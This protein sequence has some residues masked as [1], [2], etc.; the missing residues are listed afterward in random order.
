MVDE[1]HSQYYASVI[2]APLFKKIAEQSLRILNR[3][4]TEVVAGSTS[5]PSLKETTAPHE[6]I[7]AGP[8]RWLMPDLKGLSLSEAMRLLNRYVDSVQV[9][10]S[11]YVSDQ[12]PEP[13]ATLDGKSYVSI[14]LK[15]F[16]G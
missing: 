15:G 11:G 1:P 10:G 13:G 9:S 2:A 4:S 3:H 8:G 7:T 6:L 14:H 16:E 5:A 12:K